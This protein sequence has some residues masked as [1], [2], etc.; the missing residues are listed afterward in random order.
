ML[1]YKK[2]L[3]MTVMKSISSDYHYSNKFSIL[4]YRKA[5]VDSSIGFPRDS[6]AF[7]VTEMSNGTRILTVFA[8]DPHAA[9]CGGG[10]KGMRKT[11]YESRNRPLT[12]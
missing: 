1:I 3:P 8:I 10:T 6:A 7:R 4:L 5:I 9:P 12:H 2:S 11:F